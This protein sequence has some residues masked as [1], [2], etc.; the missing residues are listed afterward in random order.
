MVR[1]SKNI[2]L[3]AILRKEIDKEQKELAA[4]LN[5][6][7]RTVRRIELKKQKLTQK[8][9][10]RIGDLYDVDP[11]C[12]VR[13]DLRGGL[14]TRDGRKWTEKTRDEIRARLAR[15]GDLEVYAR[16]AQRGLSASLLYQYLKISHIIRNLPEPEDRLMEWAQLFHLAESAL[17]GSQPITEEWTIKDFEPDTTLETVLDDL[18]AIWSDQRLI[19]RIEKRRIKQQKEKSEWLE[20]QL[21]LLGLLGGFTPRGAVAKEVLE[22]LGP[23]RVPEMKIK[24]LRAMVRERCLQEGV[25]WRE[26]FHPFKAIEAAWKDMN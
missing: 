18:Q 22:E 11:D 2:H 16:K 17:T 21:A 24:E 4:A 7:E 26:A 1:P 25:P 14:R 15:W 8:L 12:L 9:A 20:M 13:N 3:L 19:R 10:E 23:K 6:N 5:V